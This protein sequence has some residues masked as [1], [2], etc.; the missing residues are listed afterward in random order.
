MDAVTDSWAPSPHEVAE[1]QAKAVYHAVHAVARAR[2][3][4]ER[5]TGYESLRQAAMN[6]QR[7][8]LSADQADALAALVSLNGRLLRLP[9]TVAPGTPPQ[10]PPQL[11]AL[12][13]EM[14]HE[15][16]RS[17]LGQPTSLPVPVHALWSRAVADAIESGLRDAG[18]QA[19]FAWY[20]EQAAT[21]MFVAHAHAAAGAP[22]GSIEGVY[23]PVSA[24]DVHVP[25]ANGSVRMRQ[26]V[27]A[28]MS[29]GDR[30]RSLLA[31]VEALP[32]G[33]PHVDETAA[34]RRAAI[35]VFK[36]VL[37]ARSPASPP[38]RSLEQA[39]A[40][41]YPQRRAWGATQGGAKL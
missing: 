20:V 7:L 18:A 10:T 14:A 6:A 31:S 30:L 22:G 12:A 33:L 3:V 19:T 24:L 28:A 39:V 29:P 34:A 25:S 37:D 38:V 32:A 21:A 11:P 15:G 26:L 17:V 13:Q 9:A 5:A 2:T 23:G 8:I 16:V 40:L 4:P 36:A 1:A 35:S 41:T 27:D